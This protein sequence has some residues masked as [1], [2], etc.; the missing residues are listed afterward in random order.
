MAEATERAH[1]HSVAKAALLEDFLRGYAG[2]E[3]ATI[4]SGP[5]RRENTRFVI[6]PVVVEGGV[7][8]HAPWTAYL[9]EKEY[10]SGAHA[11]RTA[12][13]SLEADAASAVAWVNENGGAEQ[14][15]AH[16]V[17]TTGKGR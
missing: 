6:R 9:C 1:L 15:T 13:R 12:A 10:L 11:G 7:D 8:L 2:R 14:W 3:D 16:W 5:V 4:S 17:E